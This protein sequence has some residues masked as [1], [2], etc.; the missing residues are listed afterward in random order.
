MSK[1]LNCKKDLI[2][3]Q[4]KYCSNQCQQQYQYFLYIENWKNGIESGMGGQFGLSHHIKHYLLE[5]NNYK[6][7]KCGWGEINLFTNTIPLEVHHKDGDYR[8][9]EE[10]N[11]ELLCPNCHSLTET[12]RGANKQGRKDRNKYIARKNYCIDCGIEI[13]STSTRCKKCAGKQMQTNKPVS[14]T[15]L[16][17]LIKNKPF[18]Q[19]AKQFNVSDN[20]IRKWCDF[21]NL[22]RKVSD[23]KKYSD[24]QWEKV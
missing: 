6:C 10:Q 19:I 5:K 22:P 24:E 23:I 1:C 2:N 20:T 3:R 14:R 13:T 17:N 15:E 11:L 21:Y 4:T 8:N 7:E 9:N 18:K 12:F 16:K